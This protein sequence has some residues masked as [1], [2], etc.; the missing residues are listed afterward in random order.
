MFDVATG[1]ARSWLASTTTDA[2]AGTS[3][4]TSNTVLPA[5]VTR[6]WRRASATAAPSASGD[7]VSGRMADRCGQHRVHTGFSWC[8]GWD[9]HNHGPGQGQLVEQ[10]GRDR[11]LGAELRGLPRQRPRE[12]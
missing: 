5:E 7:R 10:A 9:Q 1:V 11:H 8:V 3:S 6:P 4:R 2:T 12:R